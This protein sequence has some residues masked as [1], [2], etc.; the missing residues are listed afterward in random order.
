MQQISWQDILK[1][2]IFLGIIIG[3]YLLAPIL[4]RLVLTLFHLRPKGK[5]KKV[6]ENGF[7]HPL[8]NFFRI[9]GIYLA[10][11]FLKV[12]ADIFLI[13]TKVFKI[14]TILLAAK[15]LSNNL[16]RG[17]EFLNLMQRRFH[18]AKADTTISL[19]A[20][21]GKILIYI[22]AGV[23]I[24][25]DLGYNLNGLLA[26]FGLL[27][28]VVTLA[29]QDTAKNFFGGLIVLLD[30]SFSVGDWVETGKTEG[31]VEDITFRSTRIRTFKDAII[32]IP[33]AVISN[34]PIIN[35]SK[36]NKR[37]INMNLELSLDTPLKKV[38]EMVSQITIMLETHP[39]V[40]NESLYVHF[41]QI[42]ENGYNIMV[43][44][45]TPLTT[46]ADYLSL[47]ENVNYKIVHIVEN[48]KISLAYPSRDI[49]IKK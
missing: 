30:K 18:F 32:T 42:T 28:V 26:G 21:I 39:N 9:L 40:D 29:A 25:A 37:K 2:G 34:D 12:P 35:W 44:Y 36:M 31:I 27:S 15:A 13:V 5:K 33:N 24:L 16:N 3:F 43:S 7:Y 17:S 46:Y 14:L 47:K 23:L 1:V 10:I 8:K 48:M 19:F 6:K 20:K 11:M 4:S 49:Y 41:D 22:V 45:Y 38:N